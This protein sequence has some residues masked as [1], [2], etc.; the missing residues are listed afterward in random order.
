LPGDQAVVGIQNEVVSRH[1][2]A[3]EEARAH[4]VV[5]VPGVQRMGGGS[6]TRGA[7]PAGT[8]RASGCCGEGHLPNRGRSSRG[9]GDWRD[10]TRRAEGSG[11]AEGSE[12]ARGLVKPAARASP[13]RGGE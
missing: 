8:T 13:V 7:P 6:G 12:R 2:A 5:R 4:P 9:L 10:R 1:L 3:A 11:A